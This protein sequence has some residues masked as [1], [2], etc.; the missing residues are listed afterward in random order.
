MASRI[1]RHSAGERQRRLLLAALRLG[2]VTTL[3]ARERVNVIHP[4]RASWNCASAVTAS[5]RPGRMSQTPGAAAYRI[6]TRGT[7]SRAR[8]GGWKHE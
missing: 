5:S 4:A 3:N 6:A 7:C 1:S 8:R 2:P